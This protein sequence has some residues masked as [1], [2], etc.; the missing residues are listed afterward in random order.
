MNGWLQIDHHLRGRLSIK[1]TP[2]ER[3]KEIKINEILIQIKEPHR[4]LA[5]SQAKVKANETFLQS[6][7]L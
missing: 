3:G 7:K 2:Q 5:S 1:T 6:R 4:A